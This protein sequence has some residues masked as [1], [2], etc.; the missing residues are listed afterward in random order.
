MKKH[1]ISLR[2]DDHDDVVESLKVSYYVKHVPTLLLLNPDGFEI[3]RIIDLACYRGQFLQFLKDA[4]EGK[5][6]YRGVWAA[7][8]KD[9]HNIQVSYKLFK[10]HVQ[11]GDLQGIM[12]LGR[13]I[14]DR[15][16]DSKRMPAEQP[17]RKGRETI[18]EDTR[19]HIRT[20]LH[21]S[22]KE[23]ILEHINDF[24]EVKFSE[25]AYRFVARNYSKRTQWKGADTFFDNAL[26]HY[27]ESTLLKKYFLDYEEHLKNMKK[28]Y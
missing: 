18:Y 3:D 19:Y 2:F 7:H 8:K 11:R 13:K 24:P 20:T 14:L 27:P 28:E 4:Y 23:D 15:P 17:M 5:N 25:R 6:T 22:S 26:R 21:R 12:S 10:K 16:N 9:P 1:T